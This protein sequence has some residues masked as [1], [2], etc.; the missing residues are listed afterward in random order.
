[1]ILILLL[2]ALFSL[3]FPIGKV[4]MEYCPPFFLSGLRMLLGG[5]LLTGFWLLKPNRKPLEW[6]P[7]FIWHMVLIALFNVYL[8]NAFEL[9]GLQYMSSAKTCFIYNLAPLFSAFFSYFYYG[10]LMTKKKFLGLGISLAG[11]IP[12]LMGDSPAETALTHYWFFSS[13]EIALIIATISFVYGWVIMQGLVRHKNY[14]SSSINGISMLGASIFGF[15][16]SWFME[17]WG[18]TGIPVTS[19]SPFIWW[20][21]LIIL[22][23]NIGCYS[24]YTHLLKKYTA[25][26]IAFT[27]L[28]GPLFAALF[29][30]IFFGTAVTWH[31]YLATILVTVGLSFFYQEDLRQGYLVQHDE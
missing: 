2:N 28:T 18:S 13:A 10:E 8:T 6:T 23:S 25:T 16:Q 15:V 1:M 27:G 5:A 22:V 4:A 9:W 26:F 11:F 24:I 29:D 17:S 20:L 7:S 12:I 21:L 31:F 19:W 30:W 14:D 3:V